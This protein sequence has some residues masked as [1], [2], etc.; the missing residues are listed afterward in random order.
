MA[1]LS[2]LHTAPSAPSAQ[3]LLLAPQG[4]RTRGSQA[5][6]FHRPGKL[7]S[8]SKAEP[9]VANFFWIKFPSTVTILHLKDVRKVANAKPVLKVSLLAW[10][11]DTHRV[12]G[13]GL[14]TGKLVQAMCPLGDFFLAS[15]SLL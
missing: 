4:K 7:P 1:S 6:R 2:S 3:L 5:G 12:R 11:G 14:G 15:S 9:N 13:P 10:M 8:H